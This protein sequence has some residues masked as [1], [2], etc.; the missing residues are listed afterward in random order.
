MTDVERQL[1]ANHWESLTTADRRLQPI[2][3][4]RLSHFQD[5]DLPPKCQYS[6]HSKVIL[7]VQRLSQFI[8]DRTDLLIVRS[9]WSVHMLHCST[10]WK[11]IWLEKGSERGGSAVAEREGES[12]NK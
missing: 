1:A 5:Q 4:R 11:C 2:L 12:I 8:L 9:T 3:D 6:H 7:D 10:N